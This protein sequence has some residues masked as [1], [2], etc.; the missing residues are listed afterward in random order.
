MAGVVGAEDAPPGYAGVAQLLGSARPGPV[1]GDMAAEAATV[2]TMRAAILGRPVGVPSTPRRQVLAKVLTAKAAA[3]AAVVLLGAGTAAAATGSLPAGAQSTAKGV[4][5]KIGVSV[6]GPNSEST[7]GQNTSSDTKGPSSTAGDSSA[8]SHVNFGLC[9][10]AVKSAGH[11]SST[12]F[13]SATACAS[14]THPGKHKGLDETTTTSTSS[15]T[16]SSTTST[17][18][19]TLAPT[20]KGGDNESEAADNDAT[21][22]DANTGHDDQTTTTTVGSSS[23]TTGAEHSG[24]A[25]T[26]GTSHSSG[27]QDGGT[28]TGG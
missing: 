23:T 25:S 3:A 13:P 4:L 8:N 28:H 5:S 16:T 7:T 11:P 2:A 10:A 20:T 9:N 21:E 19:T 24:N 15:T 14:V 12:V 17:T 1:A 26:E 6:P 27:S 22:T 18:A